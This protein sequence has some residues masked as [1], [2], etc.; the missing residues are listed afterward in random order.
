MLDA[1]TV[2]RLPAEVRLWANHYGRHAVLADFPGTKL[3]LLLNAELARGEASWQGERRRE[4]LPLHLAPRVTHPEP[5]DSVPKRLRGNLYHARYIIF[6]AR[7][8]L[9]QGFRYLR[10]TWRWKRQLTALPKY[11]V[12]SVV[13]NPRLTKT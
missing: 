8:H 1:W 6:R 12:R 13:K 11:V 5:G 10:E 2:D 7:F 3:Y 4:L 9:V